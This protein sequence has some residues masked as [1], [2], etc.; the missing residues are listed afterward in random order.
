MNKKVV[1][2]HRKGD[3]KIFQL[4]DISENFEELEFSPQLILHNLFRPKFIFLFVDFLHC[5]A[6]IWVGSETT[7]RMKF[8]SAY[9]V[10]DIK[11]RLGIFQYR[12]T[13]IMENEET[14]LFKRFIGNYTQPKIIHIVCPNCD[15]EM[16]KVWIK[17]YIK[18][19]NVWSQDYVQVGY[20]CS[21][22]EIFRKIDKL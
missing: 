16:K 6:W 17:D 5:N 20:Y 21:D 8:I 18:R 19:S 4:N 13:T 11:N 22:C 10:N 7:T 1:Y 14:N 2:R 9:K 3:I 12:V 15:K